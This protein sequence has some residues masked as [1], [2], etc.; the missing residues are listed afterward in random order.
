MNQQRETLYFHMDQCNDGSPC[1]LMDEA[2]YHIIRD[3]LLV[4]IYQLPFVKDDST[5][6]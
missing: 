1:Y 5:G 3:L 4:I 6:H 2:E